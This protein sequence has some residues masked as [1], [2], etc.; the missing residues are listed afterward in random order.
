MQWLPNRIHSE[1]NIYQIFRNLKPCQIWANANAKKIFIFRRIHLNA[2]DYWC[3]K[4]QYYF[5]EVT[6][7]Q[8]QYRKSVLWCIYKHEAH[9]YSS[10]VSCIKLQVWWAILGILGSALKTDGRKTH[11]LIK[12]KRFI[13]T[14]QL[15][16]FL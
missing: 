13:Y 4:P 3:T 10:W 6:A 5:D 8:C 2:F 11:V 12:I 14:L 7:L 1:A 16:H 9:K 15:E